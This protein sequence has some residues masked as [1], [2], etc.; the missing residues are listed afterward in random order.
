MNRQHF[1]DAYI[2]ALYDF[3]RRNKGEFISAF[4]LRRLYILPSDPYL[5]GEVSETL[6][7]FGWVERTRVMAPP[8]QQPLVINLHG[9]IAAENI[10]RQGGAPVP[11]MPRDEWLGDYETIIPA[12]DRIVKIGDNSLK[13]EVLEKVA[14]SISVIEGSNSLGP[15]EK[16]FINAHLR[17][18]VDLMKSTGTFV[19]GAIRYLI[20]D[21]LKGAF[22]SV[23][24]DSYKEIVKI[25]LLAAILLVIGSLY[26]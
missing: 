21:R 6:R 4:E 12:S 17:S 13:S 1:A 23:L 5:D 16:N 24:E 8:D 2:V 25:A 9:K 7:G 18:G 26:A 3:D 11:K 15:D 20:I 14:A 19:I 10:I 22:E